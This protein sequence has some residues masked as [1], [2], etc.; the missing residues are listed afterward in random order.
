L[1]IPILKSGVRVLRP[2]EFEMVRRGAKK[3]E[4]QV[5]LDALLL[6]GLRYVEA[7]RLQKHPKWFD[8]RFIHL[9]EHAQRKAKRRQRER[10][11]RLNPQGQQVL[12]FFFKAPPLPSWKAWMLNLRRWAVRGGLDPVGLSPKTTR[13]T[14]ES[15]L[16]AT[17]PDRVT[18]I[19]LSQGHTELTSLKFYL[20]MPFT[21][22][23]KL[24]MKRWVTGWI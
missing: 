21:E 12:P 22:V 19:C 18:E 20:N 15:W 6:T 2:S 14:W 4:N 23:D 13:K 11:I 17:Y 5:R 16:I 1:S 10:W 8:G 7:Q 3:L 9:P 24:E